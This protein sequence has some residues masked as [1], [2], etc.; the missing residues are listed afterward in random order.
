MLERCDLRVGLALRLDPAFLLAARCEHTGQAVTSPH[1]FICTAVS[2]ASSD[3]CATS[4]KPAMGRVPVLHKSG[5]SKTWVEG[6][7][8]VDVWQVWVVRWA[9]VPALQAAAWSDPSWRGHRNYASIDWA[10][11]LRVAA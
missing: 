5:P 10:T 2:G 11:D 1:W 6:R 4:S 7:T 8:F 9:A 3:W